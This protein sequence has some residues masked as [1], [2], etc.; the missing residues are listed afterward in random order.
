MLVL[1]EILQFSY[2]LPV[3]AAMKILFLPETMLILYPTYAHITCTSPYLLVSLR[4]SV[5]KYSKRAI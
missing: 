3:K 4:F 5:L 1:A 2:Y